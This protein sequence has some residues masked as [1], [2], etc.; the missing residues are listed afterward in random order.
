MSS[1]L[2]GLHV[3]SRRRQVASPGFLGWASV[4]PGAPPP[5]PPPGLLTTRTINNTSGSTQAGDVATP[6]FGVQFKQG[7]IPAGTYPVFKKTDGTVLGAT[8]YGVSSWDDGSMAFCGVIVRWPD[9][10]AGS[11]TATV[12]IHS[13]GSAPAASSRST[14]DLT[15]ADLKV[16]VTGVVNL[17]GTYTSSLNDGITD[18]DDIAVIGDGPA[19]KLWR[20]GEAFDNGSPHGQLYCWHYVTALQDGSGNLAGL[21][22]LGRCMNGWATVATDANRK[23]V[24]AVLKSGATTLRTLSGHDT[25]ETPGSNIG[26][27]HYSSFFTAGT[28]AKYDYVQGGGSQTAEATLRITLDSTAKTYARATGLFAPWDLTISPTDDAS[29]DYYPMGKAALDYRAMGTT[30]DA[31]YI[32]PFTRANAK[33]FIL[34]SATMER[35]CRASGLAVGGFRTCLRRD[36]T[37]ALIPTTTNTYT[38]M[39]GQPTWVYS[40]GGSTGYVNPA[41]NTSLWDG[42]AST[43]HRPNWQYYTYMITAERQFLDLLQELAVEGTAVTTIVGTP[44]TLNA[45]PVTGSMFANGEQRNITVGATTYRGITLVEGSAPTRQAAWKTRCVVQALRAS[46]DT[47]PAGTGIKDFLNDLVDDNFAFAV[48]VNAARGAGWNDGGFWAFDGSGLDTSNWNMGYLYQVVGMAWF[49]TGGRADIATFRDHL[50]KRPEKWRSQGL[51]MAGFTGFYLRSRDE[52]GAL[53]EDATDTSFMGQV[54]NATLSWNAG[55]DVFTLSAGDN[56]NFTPTNGDVIGFTGASFP[57]AASAY[58]PFYVVN[59]SGL[60]F[61]LAD[62]PGGAAKDV[63]TT[64]SVG[65]FW[66][67]VANFSPGYTFQSRTASL[68]TGDVLAIQRAGC[69]FLKAAGCTTLDDVLTELDADFT[70]ANGS[71]DATNNPKWAYVTSV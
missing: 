26:W 21:R 18:A 30:G 63:T 3:G 60:T 43:D 41:S 70:A 16:E 51:D 67:R 9:S 8:L 64:L 28:D 53:I 10:I 1:D 5:P 49:M 38:G 54:G 33:H 44:N 22:Y 42:E 34:Q 24:S 47:D 4:T 6:S 61:Q 62:T 19:G 36:T 56:G 59:A 58:Q 57:F 71:T 20:I 31:S 23:T 12:E 50:A 39:T 46:P 40:L 48:A 69:R 2:R 11:S 13:G 32:G 25:T 68:P 65:S 29:V 66:A 14:S 7:D 35:V 15:A 37:R 55:T 27:P 45:A 17:T 52:S